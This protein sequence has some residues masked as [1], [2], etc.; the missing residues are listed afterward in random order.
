[1]ARGDRRQSPSTPLRVLEG[2]EG[3][4]GIGACILILCIGRI[5]GDRPAWQ[6]GMADATGVS[7]VHGMGAGE[8]SGTRMA[9]SMSQLSLAQGLIE[10][11]GV[12]RG[13]VRR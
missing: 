2:V 11:A 13:I 8:A 5:R 12:A 10:V 9:H 1:M 7:R 3:V 4:R 6:T